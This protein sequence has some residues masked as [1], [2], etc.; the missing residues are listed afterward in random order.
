MQIQLVFVME[1]NLINWYKAFNA[2]ISEIFYLNRLFLK[3]KVTEPW[4]E[5]NID[6]DV[7]V[8]ID[9][10]I[11]IAIQVNKVTYLQYLRRNKW[12]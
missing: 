4:R 2:G 9:I 8:D 1:N 6:I 12:E 10:D 3:I 5:L 11:D 7:D